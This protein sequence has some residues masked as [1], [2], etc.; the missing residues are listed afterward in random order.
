MKSMRR[1]RTAHV[2]SAQLSTKETT[3]KSTKVDINIPVIGTKQVPSNVPTEISGKFGRFGGRFVPETLIAFLKELEAEF[4][5]A[6]H[7]T[8]F[9]VC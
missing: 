6:L 9:Q 7:D 4:N 2:V 1:A 3:P 5:W 8:Q